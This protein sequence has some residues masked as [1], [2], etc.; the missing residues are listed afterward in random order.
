MSKTNRPNIN[1]VEAV[2]LTDVA[3]IRYATAAAITEHL[4]K[5]GPIRNFQKLL[6]IRGVGP[7]TVKKLQS[8]YVV[9]QK[10]PI[11]EKK[12]QPSGHPAGLNGVINLTMTSAYS[13]WAISSKT[14]EALRSA[15]SPIDVASAQIEF[16]IASAMNAYSTLYGVRD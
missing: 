5:H 1:T 11:Q 6:D 2:H 16:V 15:R 3:G 12:R 14:A 4:A 7:A 10:T 8:V 9:A 13:Q